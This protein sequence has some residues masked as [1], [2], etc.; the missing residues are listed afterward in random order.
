MH[1]PP[2]HSFVPRVLG[3]IVTAPR[4]YVPGLGRLITVP[5]PDESVLRG[6]ESSFLQLDT[7]MEQVMCTKDEFVKTGLTAAVDFPKGDPDRKCVIFTNSQIQSVKLFSKLK[8]KLNH[9]GVKADAILIHSR[10]RKH[11]KCWR[12]CLFCS[13]HSQEVTN[14]AIRVLLSTNASNVSIDN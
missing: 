10:L 6:S 5:I 12:T 7:K 13:D 1:P 8:Q 9:A 3:T 4:D 11:D 2:P 14:V